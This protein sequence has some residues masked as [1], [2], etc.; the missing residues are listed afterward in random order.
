MEEAAVE[1]IPSRGDQCEIVGTSL[2][3]FGMPFIRYRTGDLA[4]PASEPCPCGRSH[5]LISRIVGRGCDVIV[6]PERNIVAPVAMDY[7]FY[8]L[9]EIREAQIVQESID[10]L[11]V[12]IVP[13]ESLSDMTRGTLLREIDSYLQSPTMKVIWDEV[14]EIPRT[15]GGKRPFV[16]SRINVDEYI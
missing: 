7:A 15:A 1:L 13:W 11:R 12:K 10:T 5:P 9:E 16:V 4:I 14:G 2:T 3:A 8:H 6:T